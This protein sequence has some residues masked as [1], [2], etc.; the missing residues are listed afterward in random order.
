M[1]TL[2]KQHQ[3]DTDSQVAPLSEYFRGLGK[4]TYAIFG[5]QN[6]VESENVAKII[7]FPYES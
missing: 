6:E 4:M 3:A 5:K 1:H 7:D 2:Y